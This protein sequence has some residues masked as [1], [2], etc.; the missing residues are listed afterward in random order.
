MKRAGGDSPEFTVV[1]ERGG[2][3]R[4]RA[5]VKSFRWGCV[6]IIKAALARI[7]GYVEVKLKVGMWME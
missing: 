6:D 7:L 4:G 3:E 5:G 2:L 1:L